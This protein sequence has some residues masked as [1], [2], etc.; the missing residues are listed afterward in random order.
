MT[1][2]TPVAL[3]HINTGRGAAAPDRINLVVPPVISEVV[4]HAQCWAEQ[5]AVRL[6]LTRRLGVFVPRQVEGVHPGFF[7]VLRLSHRAPD[8]KNCEV[9]VRTPRN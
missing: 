9:S 4:A 7:V 5:L 8:K 1:A 6:C 2:L 3:P